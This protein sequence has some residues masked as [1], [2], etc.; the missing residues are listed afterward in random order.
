MDS[1]S[2][3]FFKERQEL[4]ALNVEKENETVKYKWLGRI[5]DTLHHPV[6]GSAKHFNTT[7]AV[8]PGSKEQPHG[9]QIGSSTF[10]PPK[11]ILCMYSHHAIQQTVLEAFS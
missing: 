10:S 9:T 11:N 4:L 6:K 5:H 7:D 2:S 3:S 8:V 1:S